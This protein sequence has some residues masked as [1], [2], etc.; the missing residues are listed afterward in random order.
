MQFG[1]M[2]KYCVT[3]VTGQKCFDIHC[4]SVMHNFKVPV[5][6]SNFEGSKSLELKSQNKFL[7]SNIDKVLVYD[8]LSF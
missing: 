5:S 2:V 3:F 6:K 4:R 8:S 1:K 7:V